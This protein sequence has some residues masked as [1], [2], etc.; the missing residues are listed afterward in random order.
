MNKIEVSKFDW[1]CFEV[2]ETEINAPIAAAT[3]ALK[4]I[5]DIST[6]K[7]LIPDNYW[8]LYTTCVT[9]IGTA[10][11]LSV[12]KKKESSKGKSKNKGKDG[13]KKNK[14]AE[15][16]KKATATK[17]GVQVNVKIEDVQADAVELLGKSFGD[18][19]TYHASNF[20]FFERH[21]WKLLV[22]I[23][24]FKKLVKIISF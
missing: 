3:T 24:S 21:S 5:I 11:K 8:K 7:E 2:H 14:G 1:F 12:K 6:I 16:A 19:N 20:T 15:L 17:S 23:I 10:T 18:K 22:W 13:K 4:S 9:R